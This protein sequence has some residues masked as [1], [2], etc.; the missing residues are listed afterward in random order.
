[1]LPSGKVLTE[2]AQVGWGFTK[3]HLPTVGT[4]ANVGEGVQG[5]GHLEASFAIVS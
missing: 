1:M 3:D 2:G 5:Q 4:S